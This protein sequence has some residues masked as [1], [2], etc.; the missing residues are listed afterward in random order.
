MDEKF[1][2]FKV[3]FAIVMGRVGPMAEP[4][5]FIARLPGIVRAAASASCMQ[6]YDANSMRL[7]SEV[8]TEFGSTLD[9]VY[10]DSYRSV[11]TVGVDRC[12]TFWCGMCGCRGGGDSVWLQVWR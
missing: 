5:L 9:A 6:L 10:L 11:A 4:A 2:G 12:V 1:V 3:S 8:T 7:I